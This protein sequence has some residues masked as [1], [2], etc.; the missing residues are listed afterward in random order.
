NDPYC[1]FTWMMPPEIP[2]DEIDR[3]GYERMNKWFE[4]EHDEALL[5]YSKR[6]AQN[7]AILYYF[8]ADEIIK[9][10]GSEG[11]KIVEASLKEMGKMRGNALKWKLAK[12]GITLS[13]KNVFD[14]FDLPSYAHNVPFNKIWKMNIESTNGKTTM[15]VSY[16]PLAEIWQELGNKEIG[17]MFCKT[18]CESIFKEL[19]SEA[20]V[21]IIQTIIEG[22]NK[23]KLE[24]KI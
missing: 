10:F 22:A 12:A 14:N 3:S 21:E 24:F 4:E 18:Q 15:D 5:L 7:I 1:H 2:E 13:V 17:Y 8:L 9:R 19:S 6:D 20:E 16:C 11:M 23:C